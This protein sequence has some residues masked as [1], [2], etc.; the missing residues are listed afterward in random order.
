M[1]RCTAMLRFCF[2]DDEIPAQLTHVKFDYTGGSANFNP[3]TSEGCT[4]S[5]QSETRTVSAND[6]YQCFTFPYLSN[7]GT[8][9]V[10]ISALTSNGEVIKKKTIEAVPV[11]RNRITTYTGN[12]FSEG[13][14]T[15]TQSGFG[16]IVNGEW[17]GEDNYEF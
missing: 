13:E 14:G 9:K 10:T 8:L 7:A 1:N 11:T 15:I 17:E 4:K 5:T 16:F 12:L 6:T 2:T 3:T